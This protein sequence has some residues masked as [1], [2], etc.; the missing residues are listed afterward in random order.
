MSKICMFSVNFKHKSLPLTFRNLQYPIDK[1]FYAIRCFS[2]ANEIIKILA[3]FIYQIHSID[4]K[5]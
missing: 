1:T 3:I 2:F 4:I 5:K